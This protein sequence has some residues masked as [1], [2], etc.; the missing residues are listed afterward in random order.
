MPSVRCGFS[1]HQAKP[2][3]LHRNIVVHHHKIIWLQVQN[4]LVSFIVDS[5]IQPYFINARTQSRSLFR[6]RRTSL[7][8]RRRLATGG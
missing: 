2:R 4:G 1:A 3:Q 6:R 5:N 7:R 8:L